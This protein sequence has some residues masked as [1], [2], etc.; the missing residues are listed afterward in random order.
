[1]NC[2][3]CDHPQYLPNSVCTACGY[4][5]PA[6]AKREPTIASHTPYKPPASGPKATPEH[7][8]ECMDIMRAMLKGPRTVR[9]RT[10]VGGEDKSASVDGYG[11]QTR[12]QRLEERVPGEDDE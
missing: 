12:V 11:M 2:P 10:E 1:M 6:A 8:R 7:A 9:Y 5:P 3:E 4:S